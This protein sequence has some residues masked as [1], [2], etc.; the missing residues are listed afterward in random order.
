MFSIKKKSFINLKI[1][2]HAH[3][4]ILSIKFNSISGFKLLQ[5]HAYKEY[6]VIIITQKTY[7]YA[8]CFDFV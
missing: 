3:I 2:D 6:Y 1:E 5:Y 7:I 4:E 8:N